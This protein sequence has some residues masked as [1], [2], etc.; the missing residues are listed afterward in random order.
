MSDNNFEK[1]T[2]AKANQILLRM[3]GRRCRESHIYGKECTKE[4]IDLMVE[5]GYLCRETVKDE[6]FV[7][8]TSK[9]KDIWWKPKIKR[10]V[11]IYEKH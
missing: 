8:K 6:V 5:Q 7:I 11:S 2:E 3:G 1:I 10:G 4:D 9:G